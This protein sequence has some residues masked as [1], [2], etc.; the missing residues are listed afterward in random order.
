MK[1]CLARTD[2]EAELAALQRCAFDVRDWLGG[3]CD[4]SA[5][6]RTAIAALWQTVAGICEGALGT[7]QVD[8]PRGGVLEQDAD[9]LGVVDRHGRL[10]L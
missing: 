6:P 3:G 10:G 4:P 1:N 9:S 5:I 7:T 2:R 8:V